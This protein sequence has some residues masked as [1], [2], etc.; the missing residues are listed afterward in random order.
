MGQHG[1]AER[2]SLAGASTVVATA[3]T[4]REW[5]ADGRHLMSLR[6]AAHP[7]EMTVDVYDANGA[8]EDS[9]TMSE[10]GTFGAYG[11]YVWA[12]VATQGATVWRLG[13]ENGPRLQTRPLV[14]FADGP[15]QS[16]SWFVFPEQGETWTLVDLSQST[17]A[18]RTISSAHA[19][20]FKFA[21]AG[22]DLYFGDL[23]GVYVIPDGA[24]RATRVTCGAVTD[25]ALSK[26]GMFALSVGTKQVL[27][28]DL[29]TRAVRAVLPGGQQ[30]AF[31]REGGVLGMIDESL[32]LSLFDARSGALLLQESAPATNPFRPSV[33]YDLSADGSRYMVTTCQ[34]RDC[35]TQIVDRRGG[36]DALPKYDA[37][38]PLEPMIPRLA[39]GGTQ[40]AYASGSYQSETVTN[41][42][43]GA[44]AAG[45]TPGYPLLWLDDS[46]LLVNRY[47]LAEGGN[48]YAYET[49]LVSDQGASL[50]KLSSKIEDPR[51]ISLRQGSFVFSRTTGRIYQ[52]AGDNADP[53]LQIG[54]GSI[55]GDANDDQVLYV[56]LQGPTVGE[57]RLRT[58]EP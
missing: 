16:G 23:D 53:V 2:V 7:N 17:L 50:G 15:S 54:D 48:G 24:E 10:Y 43:R 45:K 32:R 9:F 39:P 52:I 46:R 19:Y 25:V 36:R 18:P 33:G 27:L 55:Y 5:S 13:D 34:Q 56:P 20:G 37:P 38:A 22:R 28:G 51:L 12:R 11:D 40:G 4:P 8:L 35:Q 44:S 42:L 49:Y 57:L 41:L 31:D 47:V 29:R 26:T 1:Q 6:S 30:L 21:M 3:G 14:S 58:Y